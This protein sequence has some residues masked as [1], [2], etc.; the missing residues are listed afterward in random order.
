MLDEIEG[1]GPIKRNALLAYFGS[2]DAIRHASI[3]ELMKVPDINA[4]NAQK[5]KAYFD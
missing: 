5:I 3:E 2:I 4:T 1:I